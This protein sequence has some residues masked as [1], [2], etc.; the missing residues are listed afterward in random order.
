MKNKRISTL[1]SSQW[2]NTSTGVEDFIHNPIL[3]PHGF[4]EW[5]L[6]DPTVIIVNDTIHLWANTVFHGILHYIATV[7]QPTQFKQIKTTISYPGAV[8]SYAYHNKENNS[9]YLF[10]EQYT[11]LSLFRNSKIRMIETKLDGHWNWSRPID[12][13]KPTLDWEKIGT[14]RVGNPYVFFDTYSNKWKMF[15]SASSIHLKD[16]NINEPL[17][18]GMAEADSLQGNWTRVSQTP[19]P[20]YDTPNNII[21]NTNNIS[22]LGIGSLKLFDNID[23]HTTTRLEGLCNRI[24]KNT[25]TNT[26]GSTISSVYSDDGGLSWTIKKSSLIAPELNVSSWKHAYVYGFDTILLPPYKWMFIYYNARNGWKN[27]IE[28]VGVS[29]MRYG[30]EGELS[31]C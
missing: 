10:Y 14:K 15:Y 30:E 25:D 8:R 18:I 31:L 16:S 22:I 2:I 27:A 12:I 17:Y 11:L 7:E 26:T 21:T 19:I 24:T 3:Q 23:N 5:L 28:T 29:R 20:I 13:L 9:V 1:N 6:G 4:G